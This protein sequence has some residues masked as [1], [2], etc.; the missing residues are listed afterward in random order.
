MSAAGAPGSLRAASAATARPT[1]ATIEGLEPVKKPSE[2][3]HSTGEVYHADQ[4]RAAAG[5][6]YMPRVPLLLLLL[7]LCDGGDSTSQRAKHQCLHP[8]PASGLSR[9]AAEYH[10]TWYE[11]GKIQTAGGAFFESECVCTQLVVTP[12][13]RPAAQP[14]DAAVLNSCRDKTPAGKF[15]NAT[16]QLV[17]MSPAGHWDETF[18]PKALG[19]F[20]N[21]TVIMQGTDSETKEQCVTRAAR[22]RRAPLTCATRMPDTCLRGS[23]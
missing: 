1:C 12:S 18:V 10:G 3:V 2:R 22:C 6:S 4:R 17:N 13:T 15:I 21:Y 5:P 23:L 7:L 20:V 19:V 14:G 9:T 8:P 16:A 11:I